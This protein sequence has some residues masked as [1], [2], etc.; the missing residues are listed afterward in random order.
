MQQPSGTQSY[1]NDKGAGNYLKFIDSEDGAEFKKVLGDAISARLAGSPRLNILDGGCGPGWLAYNLS[2]DGH[3]VIGCDASPQLINIAKSR[4]PKTKFD[5][6]DLTAALPYQDSQFDCAILSLSALD[7]ADQEAAF[8]NL[9][10]VL[11][12]GGKLIMTTVNP[13]YGYP[14]GLWK[15]GLWRFIFRKYPKLRLKSYNKLTRSSDRKFVWNK[16]LI[17]YFSESRYS[18]DPGSLGVFTQ[19]S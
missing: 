2:A 14:V 16:N 17:S 19:S 7:L 13:Y 9:R 1:Q 11:K 6:A 3:N 18:S 4:Y 5:T 12:T 15:R 10:R 8:K